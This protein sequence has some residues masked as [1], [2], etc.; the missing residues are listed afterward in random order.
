MPG[1]SPFKF[2]FVI[3]PKFSG[4]TLSAL[5]E[6]LRIANYCAGETLYSWDYLSVDGSNTTSCSGMSIPTTAIPA[7]GT[8]WDAVIIC[9]G[10]NASRYDNAQLLK[11]L[12]LLARKGVTLGAAETGTYVL[13]RAGLLDGHPATVHWHC[14]EG[15]E[16]TYPDIDL[17]E[18]LFVTDGKHMTCAGGTSGID[19]MLAHIQQQHSRTLA[20]EVSEQLMHRPI[21]AGHQSQRESGK[22]IE[23]P[24]PGALKTAIGLMEKNIEEPVSIPDIAEAVGISQRKLERLFNK[25]FQCS[26]VAF[27][28]IV[29]LQ[30]ARVLLTQTDMS[31]LDICVACGFTSSSYFSKSYTALF[32]MRPRDHRTD[33]PDSDAEPSWPGTSTSTSQAARKY[34]EEA[35]TSSKL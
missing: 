19:M 15:L 22:S 12:R 10:W 2:A 17:S 16:E 3:L 30:R 9:G 20:L 11:W 13:A 29:R 7:Q 1:R 24:I 4:M 26:A 18:Q 23:A 27:Y 35:L 5:V 31:V 8:N 6:P 28:R 14:L 25:H 33:W 32:G 21:R 34:M